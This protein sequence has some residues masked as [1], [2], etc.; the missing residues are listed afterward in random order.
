ML[1]GIK[2]CKGSK[3]LLAGDDYA[4]IGSRPLNSDD[5][6]LCRI[7]AV[8][9][10]EKEVQ[11]RIVQHNTEGFIFCV[12]YAHVNVDQWPHDRRFLNVSWEAMIELH[13]MNKSEKSNPLEVDDE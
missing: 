4:G 3:L 2:V 5:V 10:M 6:E 1:T 9:E 13:R 11:E 7:A 12:K 8:Q